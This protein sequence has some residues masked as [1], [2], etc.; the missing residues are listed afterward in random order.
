MPPKS[1]FITA[2]GTDIG[3][4]YIAT[5]LCRYL[6]RQGHS[7][8]AFKP[9]IS[10]WQEGDNDT[11]QLLRSLDLPINP[12]TINACSPWRFS[13]A[14]SPDMAAAKEGRTLRAAEIA[15]YCQD[16]TA[17]YVIIEGAGGVMVPINTTETMLD[18]MRLIDAPV[19]LVTGSYLGSLSHTLTAVKTLTGLHLHAV[20]VNETEGSTVDLAE[21][22]QSLRNFITAPVIAL[23]R[24]NTDLDQIIEKLL[25]T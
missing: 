6:V 12:Q 23:P 5:A 24:K 2:T 14:L 3:K 7:V 16:K 25:Q 19:I 17:D 4:T 21:T 22:T 1:F 11:V 15:E 8:R 9:V 18:M 13:A 20:I 10:G